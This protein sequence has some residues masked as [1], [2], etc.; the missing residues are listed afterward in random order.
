MTKPTRYTVKL[1]DHQGR[2][3][4]IGFASETK[5]KRARLAAR[6]MQA[7]FPDTPLADLILIATQAGD[8][9]RALA[10]ILQAFAPEFEPTRWKKVEAALDRPARLQREY[11]ERERRRVRE[12]QNLTRS[13]AYLRQTFRDL[14]LDHYK[15]DTDAELLTAAASIIQDQLGWDPFDQKTAH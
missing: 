8:T 7:G 14:H 3:Q 1:K 12:A 10:F 15:I 13:I 5:A 11:R 4:E 9:Q 2:M 6:A